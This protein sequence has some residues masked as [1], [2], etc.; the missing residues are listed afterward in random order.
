MYDLHD[1]LTP[2]VFLE[3]KIIANFSTFM[4][5]HYTITLGYTA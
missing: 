4:N 2:I 3:T 1:V 5:L